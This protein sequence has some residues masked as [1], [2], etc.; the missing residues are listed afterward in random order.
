MVHDEDLPRGCWKLARI[1]S[2]IV[3]R[4]GIARGAV[5]R[6]ASS[7]GSP[8][9]LQRPLQKLYP[10]EIHSEPPHSNSKTSSTRSQET[11]TSASS[12]DAS[13]SISTGNDSQLIIPIQLHVLD[14][15]HPRDKLPFKRECSY[16]RGAQ[17]IIDNKHSFTVNLGR[18]S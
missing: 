1:Q 11:S 17:M 15:S 4:D 14:R 12:D 10:L 7:S 3:G 18:M 2:L 16:E 9:I 13:V 5:V 8:T 6:V